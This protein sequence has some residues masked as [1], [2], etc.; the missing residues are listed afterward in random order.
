MSN[1]VVV[2]GQGYIPDNIRSKASLIANWMPKLTQL[3]VREDIQDTWVL[4]K[5]TGAEQS[6]IHRKVSA[7]GG[8][9]SMPTWMVLLEQEHMQVTPKKTPEAVLQNTARNYNYN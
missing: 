2:V 6:N 7:F 9:L 3:L 5:K 4:P 1:F 8:C